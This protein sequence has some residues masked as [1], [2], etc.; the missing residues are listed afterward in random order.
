[1]S[2]REQKSDEEVIHNQIIQLREVVAA[3]ENERSRSMC[4]QSDEIIKLMLNQLDDNESIHPRL[5]HI[6]S[7]PVDLEEVETALKRLENDMNDLKIEDQESLYDP[8][9]HEMKGSD[10]DDSYTASDSNS[11]EKSNNP[12][13]VR[14]VEQRPLSAYKNVE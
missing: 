2:S 9:K 13:D 1:M 7:R 11:D 5:L 10:S 6:L 4:I 14:D 3:K 12:A 8:F